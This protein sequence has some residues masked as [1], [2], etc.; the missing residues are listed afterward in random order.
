MNDQLDAPTLLLSK[1]WAP[2]GTTT[3]RRVLSLAYR[4]TARLVDPVTY[5][6]YSF[7]EWVAAGADDEQA[8]TIQAP[9]IAIKAPEVAVLNHHTPVRPGDMVFSRR[10]VMR[11]DRCTCQYCGA[12]PGFER[13][14]VDHVVPRERGGETDWDNCVTACDTCRERKGDRLPNEA[15]MTLR[16]APV[17]PDAS[18][19]PTPCDASMPVSWEPFLGERA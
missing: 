7:E 5:Q 17:R 15:Q 3:V 2:L 1:L 16:R 8:P 14:S 12:Q 10:N 6:A 19:I 4:D 13:L 11:R 18:S 9:S